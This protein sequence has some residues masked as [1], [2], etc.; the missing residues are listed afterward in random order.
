MPVRVI[1]AMRF[2]PPGRPPPRDRDVR[3]RERNL[4]LPLVPAIARAPRRRRRDMALPRR[5]LERRDPV[6]RRARATGRGPA[7]CRSDSSSRARGLRPR[8]I[9]D[10]IRADENAGELRRLLRDPGCGRSRSVRVRLRAS[11]VRERGHGRARGA[12]DG[13]RAGGRARATGGGRPVRA[14]GLHHLHGA[15]PQ[16]AGCVRRV[17]D[18]APQ[19]RAERTLDRLRRQGLR[20]RPSSSRCTPAGRKTLR[21]YAG[22]DAS[23]VYRSVGHEADPE[24]RCAA[25]PV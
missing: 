13:R 14:R 18:R 2:R 4:A 8:R 12:S 24:R 19:R 25:R 6:S 23:A 21:G 20:R 9:G 17:R 5:A 3:R 7:G 11:W 1:P 15:A 22:M 10:A 16:R